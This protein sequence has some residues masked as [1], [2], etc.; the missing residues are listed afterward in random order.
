MHTA[1]S[2]RPSGDRLHPRPLHR[3]DA[4]GVENLGEWEDAQD[5]VTT[6]ASSSGGRLAE[7]VVGG[8]KDDARTSQGPRVLGRLVVACIDDRKTG[9]AELLLLLLRRRGRSNVQRD[10]GAPRT[11]VPSGCRRRSACKGVKADEHWVG[12]GV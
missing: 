9:A 11:G 2:V 10:T 7:G 12:S 5:R 1:A 8:V 6:P 3:E 4:N